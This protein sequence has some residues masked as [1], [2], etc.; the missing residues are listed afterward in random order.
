MA[1]TPPPTITPVPTPA[2]QRGDR[3]T[4]SARVDAFITWLIV[5]V[6]EFYNIA[7]NVYN[8]AVDAYNNAV[9]AAGSATTAAAKADLTEADAVA[10]AA[11]RVQTGLDVV[12]V[13]ASAASA[14]AIAGAFVGT[15][16][17]SLLIETESK[18]FATQSGEQYTDG[19][20]MTAV[21]QANPNNWMFGQVTS[22][23]GTTLVID[24]QAVGGS[25]TYDDWNLSLTGARGA[26]GPEGPPVDI[27][28]DVHA[29][30]AKADPVD[31]DELGL[32]DSENGF[33]LKK[34]TISA[35]KTLFGLHIAPT[36]HAVLSK[37]TWAD[38]DEL[39]LIDSA[40]SNLLKRLTITSLKANILDYMAGYFGSQSSNLFPNGACLISQEYGD[41]SISLSAGTYKYTLDEIQAAIIGA[42]STCSRVDLATVP[43]SR[44]ISALK[45]DGAT[46]GSDPQLKI[47]I[48]KN[49]TK[50]LAGSPVV[51]IVDVYN[52]SG[53]SMSVSAIVQRA[54]ADN[55][56][57]AVT[58]DTT[59]ACSPS[60]VPAGWSRVICKGT[61][62]TS[63]TTGHQIVLTLT[64]GLG[65]GTSVSFTGIDYY[66]GAIERPFPHQADY[67]I[68]CKAVWQKG[69][70]FLDCAVNV[71]TTLR[72]KYDLFPV[73][74]WKTPSITKNDTSAPTTLDTVSESG[75][76]LYTTNTGS[77]IFTTWIA[78]ARL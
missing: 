54:N 63:A 9:A 55:D 22:Y 59:L 56:F 18:T 23:S 50:H 57:S 40:D 33:S 71:T 76:R 7:L 47:R 30:A 52:D 26:Q 35:L 28:V 60:T 53:S 12:A 25:G 36:I 58:T 74:M 65:A 14:A 15:S 37:T 51:F 45:I 8:N 16:T 39:A 4:F 44:C 20:W 68:G 3:T 11:D 21:S 43:P 24:V 67:Q 10:T 49:K 31:A 29:A 41:A 19:V 1:Q 5:A 77:T 38:D 17:T 69:T 72:G 62:S 34:V 73:Q 42:A 13:A 75:F 32:V 2:P 46:S 48:R 27:A 64:G 70:F 66:G 6:T 61:L 78:N